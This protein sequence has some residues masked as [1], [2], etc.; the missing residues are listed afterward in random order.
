MGALASLSIPQA[1]LL[2]LAAVSSGT[3]GAA[4]GAYIGARCNEK[5]TSETDTRPLLTRRLARC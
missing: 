3:F 4:L 1:N 5:P 2:I